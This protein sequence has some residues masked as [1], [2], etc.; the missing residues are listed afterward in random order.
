MHIQRK[1]LCLGDEFAKL[2]YTGDQVEI[3]SDN[4]IRIIG[5]RKRFIKVQGLSVNL[6][7]I[8]IIIRQKEPNCA[9]IGKENKILLVHTSQTHGF[10]KMYIRTFS[11]SSI[12]V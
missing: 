2:L 6:D 9:V 11:I 3:D 12:Q 7:Y 1:D 8:G 4:F 10:R 5:R